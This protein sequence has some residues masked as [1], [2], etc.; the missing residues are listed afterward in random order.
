ML[1]NNKKLKDDL[2]ILIKSLTKSEKG[3]IKKFALRHRNKSGNNYIMLL[4]EIEKQ[5]KKNKYDELF[6]KQ[7]FTD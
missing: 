5:T 1:I 4:D 7:K 6:L 3:Y 2:F